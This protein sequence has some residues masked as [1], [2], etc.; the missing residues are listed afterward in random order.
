MEKGFIFILLAESWQ[1][2]I[3]QQGYWLL[4]ILYTA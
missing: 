2:Y 1:T 4:I 3:S